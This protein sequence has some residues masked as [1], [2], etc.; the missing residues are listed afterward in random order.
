MDD[1]LIARNPDLESKLP[2]LI[3]L[4]LGPS[5]L[6]FRARDVWP[7]TAAVYCHDAGDVWP[8][9]V[10]VVQRVPV[11]HCARRGGAID[12]ILGR[13]REN[14]SMFVHTTARGRDVIFWQSA[15]T[16]KQSRPKVA[17][18]TARA[19]GRT[20]EVIVDSHETYPWKFTGQQATT[21]RT[22]LRVGDYAVEHD[23]QIVAVVERK[24]LVDFVSTLTGG[25]L[26]YLMVAL[27][28]LPHAALVVEERYSAIFKLD[29]VKP[30]VVA[31]GIGEAQVR[32][33]N[34][35]IVFTDTRALAQ[36][37]T[38]RFFGAAIAH[39]IEQSNAAALLSTPMKLAVLPQILTAVGPTPADMRAWAIADGHIV[40]AKGRLR[41]EVLAAYRSAHGQQ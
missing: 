8:Q 41:P 31:E 30:A 6:V 12:L 9:A 38:Y 10:E 35:P 34:V 7:R 3:R 5:G 15:R 29:R 40:A 20:L 19:S 37:W 27:S 32:F 16:T 1:F 18:P 14:R 36:E 25:K 21:R 26:S 24:S 4:P 11:V 17:V 23:G 13:G 22:A 28:T 33:P 39:R 2:Y